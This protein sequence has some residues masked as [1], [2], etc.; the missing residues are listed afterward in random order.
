MLDEIKSLKAELQQNKD[1]HQATIELLR[2]RNIEVDEL[3][4][5]LAKAELAIA[6]HPSLQ[7]VVKRLDDLFLQAEK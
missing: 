1:W 3:K 2:Q 6:K 7:Q 4:A 5:E